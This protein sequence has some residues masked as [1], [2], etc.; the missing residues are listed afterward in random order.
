MKIFKITIIIVLLALLTGLGLYSI[1]QWIPGV[2]PSAEEMERLFE[3]GQEGELENTYDISIKKLEGIVRPIGVTIYQEGTHRLESN[4]KLL[5]LLASDAVNL[6]EF[7]NREVTV[8]GVVKDT[9]E[10]SQKIMTVHTIKALESVASE[11]KVFNEIGQEYYFSYPA[12]WNYKREVGKVL[13]FEA[14]DS[15]QLPLVTILQYQNISV[16]LIEWLGTQQI[17]T[18]MSET[19]VLLAGLNG[20]RR[21]YTESGTE[22]IKNYL[23]KG[24]TVWELRHVGSTDSAKLEYMALVE[25]FTFV[26]PAE[27]PVSTE[28]QTL[29]ASEQ[30]GQAE[31]EETLSTVEEVKAT[32]PAAAGQ[33]ATTAPTSSASSQSSASTESIT[34]SGSVYHK[35]T[36]L[37]P[38]EVQATIA[39][40]YASF[41]GRTLTF[42]YPTSWFFTWLGDGYYGFTDSKT[43]KES[44]EEVTK[45]NSRIYVVVGQKTSECSYSRTKTLEA[46]EYTVCARE[47]GLES[48]V[49]HIAE[50]VKK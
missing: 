17:E 11:K 23:K 18:A 21:T 3:E 33:T 8:T 50:S 13:L 42:D 2:G 35:L 29:S 37:T 44:S 20:I 28:D 14:D 26:R 10:G 41:E 32:Q 39:K 47:P 1:S 5:V 49:D 4:N 19:Q 34:S 48:I 12:S 40:G 24:S 36:P 25:S 30:V 7:E 38:E 45:A 22:V 15:Q 46:I 27:E 16:P 43:F 31:G 6:E 9:V